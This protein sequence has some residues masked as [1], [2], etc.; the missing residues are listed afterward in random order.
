MLLFGCQ[1]K[2]G[3]EVGTGPLTISNLK[4]N[5][6]PQ[7]LSNG[8]IVDDHASKWM[9]SKNYCLYYYVCAGYAFS[10]KGKIL[11]IPSK[12]SLGDIYRN[13]VDSGSVPSDIFIYSDIR[14]I[15]YERNYNVEISDED[16]KSG[17]ALKREIIPGD[18]IYVFSTDIIDIEKTIR[19]GAPKGV[20]R[21]Y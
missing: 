1:H 19:R 5:I 2:A 20:M 3:I 8:R 21:V 12:A 15:N 16:I 14:I 18:I 9:A 10:V 13:L 6:Y 4:K 17:V 11:P 7:Q